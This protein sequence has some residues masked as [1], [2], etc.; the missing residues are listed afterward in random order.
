MKF[1]EK[2]EQ[3]S[4]EINGKIIEISSQ[5]ISSLT[6]NYYLIDLEVLFSRNPFVLKEGSEDFSFVKPNVSF[7]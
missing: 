1:A 5:N 4:A 6:L 2:E 3:L 7:K